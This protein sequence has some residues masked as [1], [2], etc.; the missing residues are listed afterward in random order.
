M[1]YKSFHRSTIRDDIINRAILWFTGEAQEEQ[2]EEV[3]SMH[4]DFLKRLS[5]DVKKRV[6]L[7]RLLQV[8]NSFTFRKLELKAGTISFIRYQSKFYIYKDLYC[9]SIPC[10]H[11]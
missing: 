4:K 9:Y 11:Q 10:N 3:G 2:N 1:L 8:A 5:V 7:L 6:D